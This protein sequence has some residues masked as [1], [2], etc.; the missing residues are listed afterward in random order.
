[1]DVKT[2]FLNYYLDE[3]VYMEQLEGFVST[4]KTRLCVQIEKGPLWS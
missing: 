3:E 2:A 4:R 1:M